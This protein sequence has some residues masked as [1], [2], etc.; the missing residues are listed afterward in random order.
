MLDLFSIFTRGG[1]VLWDRAFAPISGN[2]INALVKDVLIEERA[3]ISSYTKDSYAFKW[4]F[5]N[6]LDLVFVVRT[7]ISFSKSVNLSDSPRSL[8]KA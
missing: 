3:G 2:P 4:V 5:A 8:F 1:I 6:E 7:R